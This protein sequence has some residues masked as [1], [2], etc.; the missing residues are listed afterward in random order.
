MLPTQVGPAAAPNWA[1]DT[2]DY[3]CAQEGRPQVGQ[4]AV[5][6]QATAR[7]D[8]PDASRRTHC[9][10]RDDYDQGRATTHDAWTPS[11]YVQPRRD[12][13]TTMTKKPNRRGR[14]QPHPRML[15]PIGR[16]HGLQKF[17]GRDVRTRNIVRPKRTN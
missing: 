13:R 17:Q 6:N 8:Y 3:L 4:A 15:H 1:A 12:I 16:S 10:H 11:Y 2:D 9:T 5:P 7:I 14:K